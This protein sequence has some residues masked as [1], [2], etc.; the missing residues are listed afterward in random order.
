MRITY[1]TS[2][3][4]ARVHR[5]WLI[6]V[7]IAALVLSAALAIGLLFARSIAR[8]L[9]ALRGAAVRAGGGDLS[10]RAPVGLG[11]PEV[12]AVAV[13]FNDTVA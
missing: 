2:T 3:V 11:P 12:R 7:A 10:T 1:P 5:Y 8:P 9:E 4:D 6:L 13:A